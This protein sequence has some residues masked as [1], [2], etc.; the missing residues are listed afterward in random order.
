MQMIE[1]SQNPV[2]NYIKKLNPLDKLIAR[3]P[4]VN[5]TWSTQN[6]VE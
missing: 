5:F 2:V 1:R 4:P 3:K 6:E